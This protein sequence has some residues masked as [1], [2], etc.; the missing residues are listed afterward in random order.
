MLP[1]VRR[2]SLCP[3][4][5]VARAICR[6]RR[7]FHR[8]EADS[9]WPSPVGR[10]SWGLTPL[11]ARQTAISPMRAALGWLPGCA[12]IGSTSP[13]QA[14]SWT[15]PARSATSWDRLAGSLPRR[16]WLGAFL[17]YPEAMAQKEPI[18]TT[19]ETKTSNAGAH[20]MAGPAFR[21]VSWRWRRD[22]NPR[23]VA[24]H[25]LSRRAL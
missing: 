15:W 23:R 17:E 9:N 12:Q 25:A 13:W 10:G 20:L 19:Y 22:L 3:D 8:V 18:E 5:S 6:S 21:L 4:G 14:R 11:A 7:C 1:V 24:P 16:D 2:S